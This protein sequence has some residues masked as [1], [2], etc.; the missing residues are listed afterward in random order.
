MSTLESA[1]LRGEVTFMN[2]AYAFNILEATRVAKVGRTAL[3]EAI[4]AGQLRA[5]KRGRR[6]LILEKDLRQWLDRLPSL[7][8]KALGLIKREEAQS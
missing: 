8:P 7:K 2:T 4:A 6:T 5:V 3:Y 1:S